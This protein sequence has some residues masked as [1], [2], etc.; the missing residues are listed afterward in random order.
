[1]ALF[2]KDWTAMTSSHFSKP[3]RRD[4]MALGFG[5]AFLALGVL[6]LLRSAGLH[7]DTGWLYSLILVG[8]GIAGLASA[9]L[10]E[11]Q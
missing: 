9:L 8:L 2:D 4:G 10:R 1:V 6:G 7:I 3:P 5:V 11:R